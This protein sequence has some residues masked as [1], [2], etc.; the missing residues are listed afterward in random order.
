MKENVTRARFFLHVLRVLI[1]FQTVFSI[2]A[3]V[4]PSKGSEFCRAGTMCHLLIT[5]ETVG[6]VPG[7][8][9]EMQGKQL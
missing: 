5:V 9:P 1:V 4:E 8:A 2:K 3:K 7:T 6:D